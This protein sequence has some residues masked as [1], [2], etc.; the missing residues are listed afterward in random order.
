MKERGEGN[1]AK[2]KPWEYAQNN[3]T[4][5]EYLTISNYPFAIFP[6][7]LWPNNWLKCCE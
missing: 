2:P 6:K 7:Y 5:R 3:I 1:N 4:K